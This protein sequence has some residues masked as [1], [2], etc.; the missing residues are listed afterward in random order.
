MQCNKAHKEKDIYR[1]TE[2]KDTQQESDSKN[3]CVGIKSNAWFV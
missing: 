2:N 1:R 3:V